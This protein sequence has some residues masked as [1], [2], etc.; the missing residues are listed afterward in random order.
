MFEKNS[1][2]QKRVSRK[3]FLFLEKKKFKGKKK[4]R[5]QTKCICTRIYV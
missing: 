1:P 5:K 2:F 3:E 4:K